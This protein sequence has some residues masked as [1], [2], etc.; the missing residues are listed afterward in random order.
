MKFS[1]GVRSSIVSSPVSSGT[2]RPPNALLLLLTM[3]T[4]NVALS[5][6]TQISDEQPLSV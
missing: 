5:D 6:V 4:I 1:K 3:H 2:A